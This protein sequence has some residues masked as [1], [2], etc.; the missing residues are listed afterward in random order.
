MNKTKFHNTLLSILNISTTRHPYGTALTIEHLRNIVALSIAKHEKIKSPIVSED[1]PLVVKETNPVET[2]SAD[3]YLNY[4]LLL[5][6]EEEDI[7]MY[8][9]IKI[10]RR[11]FIEGYNNF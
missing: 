2:G 3:D 11:E 1:F 4:A 6:C 10:F 9:S 5:K 8:S 7:A